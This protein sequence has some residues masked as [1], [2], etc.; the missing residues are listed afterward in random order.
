M[1]YRKLGKWGLQVSELSLGSWLTFGKQIGNNI[2]KD[3]MVAAYDNGINFFDNAEI[4]SR[5][6]SEVVMGEILK[7]T[8]WQRDSYV[9][10]TKLFFGDGG[11]LPNQT[12]LSRKH[13]MEGINASL[14]RLQLE[15]VDLLFCHRPDP[16]TPI[17]ETVFAMND[18]VRSGKAFYWGTSEWSAAEIIEAHA[19]ARRYN[20]LPPVMEQPQYNML[21]RQR[22]EAEYAPLYTPEYGMGTTIWSPLGSGLL[23]GKYNDGIPEEGTRLTMEGLEWLRERTIGPEAESNI[24][25]TRALTAFAQELGT[26]IT[27]LALAWC[28]KNPNVSTVIT[29]GSKV[30]HLLSNLKAVEVVALITPEVE[31]KIEEILQN[32]P[33]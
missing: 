7:E 27:L 8:Q 4:Y 22:F 20:L 3:L 10:S 26:S 29:G 33:Q 24:Q 12:G 13:L 14:R 18:I 21:H 31:A 16:L 28:L 1:N 25:K 6:Q 9:V 23:T 15:Y 19:I 11:K 5:G 2:A 30:E 17:E 32:K